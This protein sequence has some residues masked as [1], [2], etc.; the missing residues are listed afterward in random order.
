LSVKDR[1]K[2][3]ALVIARRLIALGFKIV[4]TPGTAAFLEKNGIEV[5]RV[6]KIHEG[7]PDVLDMVR[8]SKVDLILNTPAGKATKADETKIRSLAVTRGIPCVTTIPGAQALIT[9]IESLRKGYEVRSLQ[10]WHEELRGQRL[11]VQCPA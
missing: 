3:A 4:S 2:P 11:G 7:R 9:G 8:D 1:D 5:G 6:M 10:E